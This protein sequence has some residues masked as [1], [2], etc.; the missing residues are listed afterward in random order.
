MELRLRKKN[1]DVPIAI[2]RLELDMDVLCMNE[3]VLEIHLVHV[4]DVDV[5][6]T[7]LLIVMQ[8]LM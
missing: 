8:I 7:T 4:I 3:A 5:K 1:G 6:D 2:A